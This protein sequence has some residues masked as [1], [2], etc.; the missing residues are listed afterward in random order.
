MNSSG[1]SGRSS[2]AC[3]SGKAP[4]LEVVLS[5]DEKSEIQALDHTQPGLP[6]KP[7]RCQ[8][9]THDLQ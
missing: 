7:G 8:T 6:I 4:L 9:M 1:C 5:I 2:A 3:G